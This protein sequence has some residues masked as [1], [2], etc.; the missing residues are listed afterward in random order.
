MPLAT[1]DLYVHHQT[2]LMTG[3]YT[4]PPEKPATSEA[5]RARKA[6]EAW[7]MLTSRGA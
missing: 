2:N 5:E 6:A 1:Q 4:A 3:A 7:Q